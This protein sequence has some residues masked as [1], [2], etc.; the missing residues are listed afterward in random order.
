MLKNDKKAENGI[1]YKI[2]KTKFIEKQLNLLDK[3]LKDNS[4]LISVIVKSTNRLSLI[5]ETFEI[6]FEQFKLIVSMLQKIKENR[7]NL[8]S[9]RK[10]S[11]LNQ[12]KN[13]SDLSQIEKLLLEKIQK[14]DV[15]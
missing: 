4:T 10:E 8:L 2:N 6:F 14:N 5:N 11:L 7:E 13:D 1:I 15:C 12:N 3:V 9:L